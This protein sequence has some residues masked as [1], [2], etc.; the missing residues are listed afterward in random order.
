MISLLLPS[1]WGFSPT[2]V[3]LVKAMVFLV[4]MYGCESWTIKKVERQRIDAFELVLEKSLESPLDCKEIQPVHP[5][6]SQSW[7]F[8]GRIDAKA[9]LQYFGPWR[10]ELIHWKRPRCWERLKAG[11]GDG[12]GWYGW[13]ASLTL[14]TWV[15]VG[16]RSWWWTEKPGMLQSMGLQRVGY[17][18]V[19]KLTNMWNMKRNDTNEL[20]KQNQTHIL[21]EWA[22]G[23]W[24]EGWGKG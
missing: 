20:T 23:C 22:Y 15:W 10:K 24:G 18:W 11:E 6:G 16:S 12:R 9:E 8:I 17:D 4:V 14:W 3:C 21:R 13:M 19:T 1:C 2:R 5:K 7:I